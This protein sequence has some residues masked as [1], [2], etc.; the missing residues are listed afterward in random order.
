[1]TKNLTTEA[2][3]FLNGH[4]FSKAEDYFDEARVDAAYED[5]R[6]AIIHRPINTSTDGVRDRWSFPDGSALVTH[7]PYYQEYGENWTPGLL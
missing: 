2:R 5:L 4:K 3:Q 7:T 1:M 6:K